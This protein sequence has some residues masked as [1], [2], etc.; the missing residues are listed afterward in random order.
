MTKDSNHGPVWLIATKSIIFTLL[1]VAATAML[2]LTIVNASGGEGRTYTAMFDDVTSLNRGDDI[3]LAGVK[4]GTVKDIEIARG[5]LA[6]V[7][8]SIRDDVKID[9]DATIQIRF[10]NM[11]GQR[12]IAVQQPDPGTSSGSVGQVRPG[13]VF[14]LEHTRPA[15]DLTLLFNGFRPLMRM[16]EPKDVN[17]LSAQIISVFQGEDA[18]VDGLLRS[19]ASLTTT[20][21]EK[22]QVIGQLINSLSSVMTEIDGRSSQLDTTLVTMQRLVSG[23]SEDRTT[24]G[25]SIEGIGALSTRVSSMIGDTRPALRGSIAHLGTLSS[26]LDKNSDD[27]ENFLKKTPLKLDRI[28]RTGSYGSWLNFYLCS[29]E[30]SIPMVEGYMGD[31]GVKP[32]AGRCR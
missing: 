25:E 8:M 2:G 12:Y 5:R 21:A 10:R 23:L 1:T 27:V 4:V 22:D 20:L 29:M 24:I 6:R 16:L 11:V 18:T 19:T 9:P 7:E 28:G 26:T 13:H 30:G 31:V 17:N 3:R 14:D 15:L 32:V